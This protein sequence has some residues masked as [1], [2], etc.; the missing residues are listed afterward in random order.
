METFKQLNTN[1][2]KKF[3][4]APKIKFMPHALHVV[5]SKQNI[6]KEYKY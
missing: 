4:I 5:K 6:S 3:L 2:R 1:P